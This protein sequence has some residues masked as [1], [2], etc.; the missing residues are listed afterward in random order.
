MPHHPKRKLLHR[1]VSEGVNE[2]EKGRK[3]RRNSSSQQP[4]NINSASNDTLRA[5]NMA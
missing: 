3:T 5:N 2:R 1:A 4:E